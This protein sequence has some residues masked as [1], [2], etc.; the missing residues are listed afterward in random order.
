VEEG[1]DVDDADALPMLEG[2]PLGRDET[3]EDV[4]LAVMEQIEAENGLDAF[5]MDCPDPLGPEAPTH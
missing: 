3:V 2:R 4:F 5:L 1:S